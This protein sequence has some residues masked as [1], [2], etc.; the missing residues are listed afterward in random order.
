MAYVHAPDLSFVQKILSAYNGALVYRVGHDSSK[1]S[2]SVSEEAA[3]LR[4]AS[5]QWKIY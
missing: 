1:L 4:E 2:L 3:S 5:V